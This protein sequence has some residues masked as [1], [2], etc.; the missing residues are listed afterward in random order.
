M[1]VTTQS[2]K[3]I[4]AAYTASAEFESGPAEIYL[5]LI[6]HGNRVEIL[7]IRINS[8]LFLEQ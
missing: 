8:R 5:S 4:S 1:S 2:G 3:V 7:G 6:K